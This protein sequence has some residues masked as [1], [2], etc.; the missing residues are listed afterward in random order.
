MMPPRE[1]DMPINQNEEAVDEVYR[2][3]P[4]ANR[5]AEADFMRSVCIIGDYCTL[6]KE[7]L[8]HLTSEEQTYVIAYAKVM[9]ALA[10]QRGTHHTLYCLIAHGGVRGVLVHEYRG[11]A[12]FRR[13]KWDTT[14]IRL[15][16]HFTDVTAEVTNDRLLPGPG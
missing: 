8:T 10:E 7:G 6:T 16:E 3:S 12:W 11:V 13:Q 4:Y 2:R 1:V 15:A 9:R 5:L 14:D